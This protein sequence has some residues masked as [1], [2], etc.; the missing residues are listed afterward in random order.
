MLIEAESQKLLEK[1]NKPK[2]EPKKQTPMEV[3]PAT[4][5]DETIKKEEIEEV[6]MKDAEK[7]EKAEDLETT[8]NDNNDSDDLTIDIDP[9]TFCKLGHFHLLLGDFAKG[10]LYFLMYAKID[11]VSRSLNSYLIFICFFLYFIILNTKSYNFSLWWCTT[12]K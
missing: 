12:E 11:R 6:E 1:H 8:K 3:D 4:T 9:K 5:T 10:L 7:S 2:D